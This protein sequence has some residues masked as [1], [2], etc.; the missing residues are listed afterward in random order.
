MS[1]RYVVCV[2]FCSRYRNK[3]WYPRSDKGC[4]IFNVRTTKCVLYRLLNMRRCIA[5]Y[6]LLI[7]Q[8]NDMCLRIWTNPPQLKFNMN[9]INRLKSG[10][11]SSWLTHLQAWAKAAYWRD[12]IQQWRSEHPRRRDPALKRATPIFDLHY[13][14]KK[15]LAQ[16]I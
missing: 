16:F 1:H 2:L 10:D 14:S 5:C 7:I 12:T 3:W 13:L 8:Q 9:L 6:L 11:R 4:S 15:N